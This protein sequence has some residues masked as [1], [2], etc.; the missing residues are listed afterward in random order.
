LHKG[1]LLRRTT[2]KNHTQQPHRPRKNTTVGTTTAG[3]ITDAFV[4]ELALLFAAL[5]ALTRFNM[6]GVTG[7]PSIN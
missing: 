5:E 2:R 7:V 1:H 6:P 4:L 3:T